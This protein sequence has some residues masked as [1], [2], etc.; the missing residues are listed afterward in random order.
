MDQA[1][2]KQSKRIECPMVSGFY[3]KAIA[4]MTKDVAVGKRK[5]RRLIANRNSEGSLSWRPG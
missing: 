3:P 5:G 4:N 1:G 2:Q